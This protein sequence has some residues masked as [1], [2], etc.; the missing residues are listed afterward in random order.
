M[1]TSKLNEGKVFLFLKSA[2]KLRG[3]Q[4]S[5]RN[6]WSFAKELIEAESIFDDR[7]DDLLKHIDSFDTNKVIDDMNSEVRSKL[8]ELVNA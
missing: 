2:I 3:L 6:D 5:R 8:I 7:L 4:K 1:K